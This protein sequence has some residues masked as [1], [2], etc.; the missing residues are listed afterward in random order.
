MPRSPHRIGET[1]YPCFLTGT[2]VGWRPVFTRPQ[3]VQIVVLQ[4]LAE[5][6]GAW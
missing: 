3:A 6:D 1:E 5:Q 4:I 2:V